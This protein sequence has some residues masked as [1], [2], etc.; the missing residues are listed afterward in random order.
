[1]TRLEKPRH[2]FIAK[3][4]RLKCLF[5]NELSR[6]KEV[7]TLDLQD[8]DSLFQFR[9][10]NASLGRTCRHLLAQDIENGIIHFFVWEVL[11]V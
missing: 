10:G 9:N 4:K 8:I 11:Q 3:R 7:F 6:F 1:M 2:F 5:H